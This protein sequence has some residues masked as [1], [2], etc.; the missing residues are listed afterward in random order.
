[1]SQ[2]AKRSTAGTEELA[3][4][5]KPALDK[6]FGKER[7]ISGLQRRPSAYRS[8]FLLEELDV[9]LEDGELLH[10]FA[11]RTVRELAIPL[12]AALSVPRARRSRLQ[13]DLDRLHLRQ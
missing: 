10:R 5:L 13:Q 4:A 9:L 1:M 2:A 3:L 7:R 8:S 12:R 6:H 11:L